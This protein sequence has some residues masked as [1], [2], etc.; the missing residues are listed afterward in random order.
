MDTGTRKVF[1]KAAPIPELHQLQSPFI[2]PLGVTRHSPYHLS[3]YGCVSVWQR[4][5]KLS[6]EPLTN[7]AVRAVC[8]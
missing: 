6:I 3:L 5:E 7:T 8:T 4:P 1:G 2:F